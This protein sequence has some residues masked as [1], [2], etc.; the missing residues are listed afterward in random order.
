MTR[1][2]AMQKT[3]VFG[4]LGVLV[5]VGLIGLLLGVGSYNNLVGVRNNVDVKWAQV[6]NDYQRRADLI[7]NLVNTVRAR[8]TSRNPR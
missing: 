3:A 6:E 8:P 2:S 7:P 4:C 1:L 5:V